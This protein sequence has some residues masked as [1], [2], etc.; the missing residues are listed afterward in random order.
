MLPGR[1]PRYI[2][3]SARWILAHPAPVELS[4]GA[5]LLPRYSIQA[6]RKICADELRQ[7]AA[8]TPATAK[9]GQALAVPQTVSAATMTMTLPIA[10]LREQSHTE[11]TLASPSL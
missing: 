9:S 2:F 7:M 8:I 1:K 10:S 5:L 3:R 4:R 6:C 11:R